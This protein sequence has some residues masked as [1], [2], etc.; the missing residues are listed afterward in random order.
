MAEKRSSRRID[1]RH[2]NVGIYLTLGVVVLIYGSELGWAVRA[3]PV[4][5]RGD[6]PGPVERAMYQQAA[7]LPAA[8]AIPLLRRS[9]EIDPNTE[10]VHILAKKLVEVGQPE[11]ARQ[12]YERYIQ[13]DPYAREAYL[14]LASLLE[15]QD[16]REQ[17]TRVLERGARH[18]RSNVERFRP[19]E[20]P[21]AEARENDKA[22]RVYAEYGESARLLETAAKRLRAQ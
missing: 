10:A 9:I 6:I 19:H 11:E 4:Y 3:L 14:E 15:G 16:K 5:L 22:R 2:L 21:A 18:F 13:I 7:K 17:A 12:H 8:E 20:D 1:L